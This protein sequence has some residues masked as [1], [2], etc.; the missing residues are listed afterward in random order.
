MRVSLNA[1]STGWIW[2]SQD[3]S[4][5]DVLRVERVTDE[6]GRPLALGSLSVLVDEGAAS[7]EAADVIKVPHDIVAHRVAVGWRAVGLPAPLHHVL[8]ISARDRTFVD[9]DMRISWWV[10]D[11]GGRPLRVDRH[12]GSLVHVDGEA[13]LLAGGL[14]DLVSRI[15]AFND[16]PGGNVRD[17][18]ARWAWVAEVLP[19]EIRIDDFLGTVRVVSATACDARL[20]EALEGPVVVPVLGNPQADSPIEGDGVDGFNSALPRE[21]A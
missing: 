7:A 5:S 11:P 21:V 16:S 2:R 6:S 15:E 17:R 1:D 12:V 20:R 18:M 14:Y 8:C 19:D 4:F 13:R 3:G 9:A 10:E